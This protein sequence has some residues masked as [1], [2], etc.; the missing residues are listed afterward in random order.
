MGLCPVYALD[1]GNAGAGRQM[2][3]DIVLLHETHLR[4]VR[5]QKADFEAGAG[6]G[7]VGDDVQVAAGKICL[8]LDAF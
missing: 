1:L 3:D 5:S 4:A 2:G 8:F 7:H 6:R